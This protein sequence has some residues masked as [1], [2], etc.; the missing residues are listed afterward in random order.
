[1]IVGPCRRARDGQHPAQAVADQ[2]DAAR[3]SGAQRLDLGPA[4]HRGVLGEPGLGGRPVAPIEDEHV[5]AAIDQGAQQ[6]PV[7]R[8]IE[9]GRLADQ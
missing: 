8:E 7:A 1:M 2:M 4:E 6:A 5:E 3:P 9:D